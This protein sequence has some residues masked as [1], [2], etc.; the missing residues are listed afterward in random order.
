MRKIKVQAI[1]C[2]EKIKNLRSLHKSACS[3]KIVHFE[4]ISSL[5]EPAYAGSFIGGYAKATDHKMDIFNELDHLCNGLNLLK[6]F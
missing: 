4:E 6:K 2:K 3:E 1:S 5:R